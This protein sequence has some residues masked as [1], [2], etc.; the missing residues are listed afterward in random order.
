MART[1]RPLG[2][3]QFDAI[4]KL[5]DALADPTRLT[6]LYALRD[7]PAYVNELVE[8]TGL[9]QAN[10]SKQLGLLFDLALVER[11]RAGN[12]VQYMVR[13]PMIFELCSSVCR[14]LERDG[15]EQAALFR[16]AS[17]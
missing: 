3:P 2:R 4:A 12:Q 5:F 17:A 6:I 10:V 8:R 1:A 13:E 15:R 7:E 14:K 11:V 9:K 16:R